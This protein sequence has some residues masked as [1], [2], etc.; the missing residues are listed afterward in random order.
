MAVA[1]TFGIGAMVAA[2][3]PDIDVVVEPASLLRAGAGSILV[4]A[5]G[6]IIPLIKVWRVDPATVFRSPS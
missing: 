5:I 3:A 6:V 1:T 4:A 2:I